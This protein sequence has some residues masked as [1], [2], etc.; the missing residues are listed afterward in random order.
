VLPVSEKPAYGSATAITIIRPLFS[1]NLF[2]SREYAM[3]WRLCIIS[4]GALG[5]ALAGCGPNFATPQLN[6]GPVGYQRA[7][8]VQYDPYFEPAPGDQP[9]GLRPPGYDNPRP[10]LPRPRSVPIAAPAE[11]PPYVPGAAPPYAPGPA[12]AYVPSAAPAAMAPAPN[13]NVTLAPSAPVAAPVPAAASRTP[14]IPA[15][16]PTP[17]ATPTPTFDPYATGR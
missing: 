14:A 1:L 13:P 12:P 4:S 3:Q 11:A 17:I 10:P 8:A 6:P 15:A 2:L 16:M 7:E 9:N 5:L